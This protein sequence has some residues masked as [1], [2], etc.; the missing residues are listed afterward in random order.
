MKSI[1]KYRLPREFLVGD[2]LSPEIIKTY[3]QSPCQ[4]AAAFFI[5]CQGGCVEV[6]INAT[7]YT[8]RNDDF[9][10][11]L[12]GSYVQL[13]NLS[14]GFHLY[15]VGFSPE[16]LE[17][18]N[19][20]KSPMHFLPAM[21]EHPVIPLDKRI[22]QLFLETY[23]LLIRAYS[24]LHTLG[25]KELIRAILS[26]FVQGTA[27][28]YKKHNRWN[29]TVNTR[30]NEIYKDFIKLVIRYYAIH[31]NVS[32]YANQLGISLPHFCTT[33]KRAIGQTPGEVIS[34]II[35]INAKGLLQ[36]TDKSIKEIAFE[37]GFTNLSF[38][39]KYFRQ[40][41]GCT[42]QEYRRKNSPKE[43]S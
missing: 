27:E 30:T 23:L 25:N 14:E 5:L 37:T 13:L 12:P 40:H 20:L 17:D 34:S 10:M 41:A 36:Y 18:A 11:L 16:L 22:A 31:H 42:P 1:P 3:L 29:Y 15:F 8:V 7:R 4:V 32:F 6:S 39:N 43:K 38:F 21:L 28:L 26:I 35:I 19:L 24:L 9:I 33:I 2:F